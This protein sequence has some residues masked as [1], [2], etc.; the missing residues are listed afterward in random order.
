[1]NKVII[2]AALLAISTSASAQQ[3]LLFQTEPVVQSDNPVTRTSEGGSSYYGPVEVQRRVAE[4]IPQPAP[5]VVAATP[6][7]YVAPPP[8][9]AP[10]PF[11]P[12]PVTPEPVRARKPDRN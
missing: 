3:E 9:V 11:V 7:P 2:A 1:M 8:Q 6:A 5:V 12:T 10:A 4:V